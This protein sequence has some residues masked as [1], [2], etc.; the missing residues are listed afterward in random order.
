MSSAKGNGCPS[1]GPSAQRGAEQGSFCG[2]MV[3]A[4]GPALRAGGGGWKNGFRPCAGLEEPN[5]LTGFSL[6]G[7][8]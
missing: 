1:H 7:G 6:P 3:T 8:V 2:D 4:A 5:T